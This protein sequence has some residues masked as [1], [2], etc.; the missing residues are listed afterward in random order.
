MVPFQQ[1]KTAT[2]EPDDED[3]L[4]DKPLPPMYS[5]VL[6]A[7]ETGEVKCSKK[8]ILA[9]FDMKQDEVEAVFDLL[10]MQGRISQKANNHFRWEG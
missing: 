8:A 2:Y 7:L 4:T 10:Q 1:V 6:E 3:T 9:A 5:Q